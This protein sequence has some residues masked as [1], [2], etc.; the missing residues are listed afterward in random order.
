MLNLKISDLKVEVEGKL[1]LRGVNLQ[2]RSGEVHVIM[3]PNGSGKSTLAYTLTGHPRYKVTHGRVVLQQKNVLKL[4]PSERA[5][6]GFFLAF[7]QPVTVEGVSV[8]R[9]LWR[10]WEATH[11]HKL[12][13]TRFK[14][15]LTQHC[16]RLGLAQE[17]LDRSLNYGFSGGEKKK[18]EIL[19]LLTLRPKVII[20]DEPDSGI[21][22]DGI[23][24]VAA[25]V[26]GYLKQEPEAI[27]V[28]ITHYSTILSYLIPDKVHL[29]IKGKIVKKGSST[30]VEQIRKNGFMGWRSL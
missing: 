18:L 16:A 1:V 29:F 26:I 23:K 30:L 28:L 8:Q 20:L 12:E 19:Q 17:F 14:R 15:Q 27:A 6:L 11:P 9:F 3:G 24:S 2:A 21:D 22:V 5:K 13:F 10:A 25:A 4:T 7:Q